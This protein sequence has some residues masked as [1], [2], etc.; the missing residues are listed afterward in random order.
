MTSER[1]E[2]AAERQRAVAVCLDDVRAIL[3]DAGVN[4][5]ALERVKGR[6]LALAAR[7]DLFSFA[8]FPLRH[9]RSTMHVLAEDE[10]DG[11]ALYAVAAQGESATPPTTTRPGRSWSAS[12]ARR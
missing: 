3:G 6:L 1:S 2:L 7:R 8:Q 4:R 10:D 5:A 9:E 11:L 12:R